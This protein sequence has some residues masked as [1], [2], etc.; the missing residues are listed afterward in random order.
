MIKLHRFTLT[1][2]DTPAGQHV[3]PLKVVAESTDVNTIQSEIFVYQ[4][5]DV[6][7]DDLFVA[8]ASV[9]QLS[10]LPIGRPTAPTEVA[11][12]LS[13]TLQFDCRYS[14]EAIDLWERVIEDT[15]DIINNKAASDNLLQ[16]LIIEV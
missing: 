9:P 8:I 3:W 11:Y 12:Y 7:E 4:L 13:D 15:K 16:E 6:P 10:E 2:E 1:P 5:R 14:E